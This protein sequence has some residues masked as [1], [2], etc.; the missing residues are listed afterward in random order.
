MGFSGLVQGFDFAAVITHYYRGHIAG[1]EAMKQAALRWLRGEYRT[2]TEAKKEL[3]VGSIVEDETWYDAL[4]LMAAFLRVAGYKGLLVCLDEAVNLYKITHTPTREAN[5]EKLLTI[6]N[7][8]MQGRLNGLGFLMGGTPQFV[9]DTR[10]GLFSYEALR[11]R[12]AAN[13]YAKEGLV[14]T[15]GPVLQLATLTPEE[16]YALL[17][18]IQAIHGEH[19]GWQ[20]AITAEELL[21]FLQEQ[22]GR[23]GADALL[24]PR[25]VIRD[26][27]GLLNVMQQNP[28]TGFADLVVRQQSAAAAAPRDD[29]AE[30][31]L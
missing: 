11:S 27:V 30:F 10:R 28:G 29:F 2:K 26:F 21:A 6:F 9:E 1:D 3:P 12:L 13:R 22:V 23:M 15:T 20:P 4:K 18:R 17:T 25:E 7:D 19:Y 14:D 31:T 8:C 16:I 5:Y 24:T